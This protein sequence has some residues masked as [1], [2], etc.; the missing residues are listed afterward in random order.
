MTFTLV[1]SVGQGHNCE[2][3]G[4][5]ED[6]YFLF[7]FFDDG[8]TAGAFD[9]YFFIISAKSQVNTP[10]RIQKHN[11][12]KHGKQEKKRGSRLS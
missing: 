10:D 9:R 11:T 3:N 7:F 1:K 4:R 8:H 6:Y 2:E 12:P 5:R